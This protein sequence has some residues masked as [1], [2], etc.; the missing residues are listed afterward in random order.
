MR[1]DFTQFFRP[2]QA[3]TG[4]A[5]GFSALSQFLQPRHF[6]GASGDDD[7]ATDLVRNSVLAAEL[8]HG[9]R[10][11]DAQLGFHR[12]WLVVDAGMNHAAVVS[13]L[14]AGNA[15]FLLQNQ[16]PTTWKAAR[17][18]ERNPESDHTTADDDYVVARIAHCAYEYWICDFK[19]GLRNYPE[20]I[21]PPRILSA[22]DG[23]L[24][25]LSLRQA[26]PACCD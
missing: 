20:R 26:S 11:T 8:D 7:F 14:V 18:F 17:D 1:L 19:L 15:V 3:Q 2:D 5:V 16:E 23:I 13:A 24:Q 25:R 21:A 4:Q 9:R 12:P 22:A 10:S 6:I